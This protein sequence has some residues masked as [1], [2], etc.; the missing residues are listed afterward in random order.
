MTALA[1]PGLGKWR[2]ITFRVSIYCASHLFFI[3]TP[4][5]VQTL[6]KVIVESLVTLEEKD[7]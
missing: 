6:V 5:D 7:W 3:F 2:G 4:I 1:L